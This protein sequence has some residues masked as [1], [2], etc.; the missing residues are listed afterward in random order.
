MHR[1]RNGDIAQ[2]LLHAWH[3]DGLPE[4]EAPGPK[5]I[6]YMCAVDWAHELGQVSSTD[7]Y[8]SV[9]LLRK[10]RSCV[11]ECGIVMVE[12]TFNKWIQQGKF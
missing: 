3:P 1:H 11:D 5:K 7:L 2:L 4:K 10:H 8:S 6:M 9:E 12:V